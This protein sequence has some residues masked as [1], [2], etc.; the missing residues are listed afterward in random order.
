MRVTTF[1]RRAAEV[2]SSETA[3]G[4]IFGNREGFSILTDKFELPEESLSLEPQTKRALTICNL[5]TNHRMAVSEI[6]QLLEDDVGQ[7]V[8]SL[9]QRKIVRDRRGKP[10]HWPSDVERRKYSHLTQSPR[11]SR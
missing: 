8:K 10:S 6:A 3:Q 11:E 4:P 7:V 2:S 9:V 5:F 1:N